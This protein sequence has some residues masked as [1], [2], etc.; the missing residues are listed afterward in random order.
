[1]PVTDLQKKTIAQRHRLYMKICR[2]CGARNAPS[3]VKC[4]KCRSKN[5]RW[6]KRELIR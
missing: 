5:L 2:Q 4:R 3:A 1:M 6:K